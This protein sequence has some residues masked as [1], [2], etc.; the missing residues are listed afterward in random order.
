VLVLQ[1]WLQ[2]YQIL[3]VKNRQLEQAVQL[4]KNKNIATGTVHLQGNNLLVR[5]HENL[6]LLKG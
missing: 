2:K 1:K 4:M 5:S 3:D 6:Q